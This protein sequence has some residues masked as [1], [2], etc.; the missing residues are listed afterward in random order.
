M[1]MHNAVNRGYSGKGEGEIV[2][3]IADVI[4]ANGA[5][6]RTSPLRS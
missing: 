1:S 5:I 4:S 2:V 6:R 3:S